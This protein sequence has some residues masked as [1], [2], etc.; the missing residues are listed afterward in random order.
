MTEVVA[1]SAADSGASATKTFQDRTRADAAVD[2]ARVDALASDALAALHEVIRKH[3]LTY[4]EY[5]AFKAWV[6]RVGQDGEWPLFLDVFVEHEVEKAANAGREGTQGSIEGPYYVAGAPSLGSHGTLPMRDGEAGVPLRFFGQVRGLTGE[7]LAG[8]EVDFWQADDGG[9]YSQFAPGIPE[10]NLRGRF[11]TDAEGNY[12]INTI[13]PAPYQI[14][15]DGATGALISA[16]GW[17]AW[18]PAHLHIKVSAPGHQPITTQLYFTGG[19]HVGSDIASA[20]KDA[21][22]LDPTPTGSG[23]EV[24]YDFVLDPA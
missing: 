12:V 17:H 1:P 5:D 4:A 14:P 22:L 21:L 24:R 18:R 11:T 3:Q 16:A 7:P 20:V 13:H 6:I 23:E 19:E 10:W 2:P 8:A 15:T 9:L